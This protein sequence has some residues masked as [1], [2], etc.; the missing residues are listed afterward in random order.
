[1][2]CILQCELIFH[3]RLFREKRRISFFFYVCKTYCLKHLVTF[4]VKKTCH[5]LHFIPLTQLVF[6]F[7]CAVF[8]TLYCHILHSCR[9]ARFFLKNQ[10]NKAK[11]SPE[12]KLLVGVNTAVSKMSL[13]RKYLLKDWNVKVTGLFTGFQILKSEETFEMLIV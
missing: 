3:Q 5:H 6:S 7:S 10:N 13:R 12:V 1:M 2:L 11:P 8:I 4:W 9:M